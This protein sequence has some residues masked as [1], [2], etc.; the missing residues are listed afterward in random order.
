MNH[1]LLRCVS[2][3][4]L[5]G[6]S[7]CATPK[8]RETAPAVPS[9]EE[10]QALMMAM[11]TA[12]VPGP[13]HE[14]LMAWAGDWTVKLRMRMAPDAPWEESAGTSKWSK[15]L[16]GRFIVQKLSSNMNMGGM[17]MQWDGLELF[18]F[19]NVTQEFEAWWFDSMST[20]G[21]YTHGKEVNGVIELR[22]LMKDPISPEGRPALFTLRPVDENHFFS[23]GYDTIPPHGLIKVIELEFT[24]VIH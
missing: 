19:N 6:I 11:M 24:R 17:E 3:L 8:P 23:E 14:K 16:G 18:G 20:T 13:E 22:G 15:A 4:L 5:A 7:S 10:Q 21:L 2:V 9:A 12:G 1:G